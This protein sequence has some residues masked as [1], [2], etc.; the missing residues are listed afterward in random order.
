MSGQLKKRSREEEFLPDSPKR[1]HCEAELQILD[2][3]EDKIQQEEKYKPSEEMV[4]GV[5]RSLEKE[6]GVKICSGLTKNDSVASDLTS[7]YEIE[8]G[9][10][11][12]IDLDYLLAASD[13]ELGI[14]PSPLRIS[15]EKQYHSTLL[16]SDFKENLEPKG[17]VDN[18]NFN[19]DWVD[20]K[21]FSEFVDPLAWDAL[22]PGP[23]I[24]G[25]FSV[26]WRLEY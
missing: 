21:Q 12:K 13:D 6:I 11:G 14:P 25:N 3:L 2:L 23:S 10:C 4:N 22:T 20:S 7:R 16:S 8:G 18:W 17:F 26:P 15:E 5:M 19:D 24:E 1:F 9:D